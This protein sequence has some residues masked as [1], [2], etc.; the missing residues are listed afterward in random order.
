MRASMLEVLHQ[1]YMRT[2]RAKGLPGFRVLLKHG[3]RNGLIPIVTLVGLSIP[4]LIG[5]AAITEAVFSWPGL[6]N[7]AVTSVITRDYPV[8]LATVMIGGVMVILGNL[9]ADVLYAVV[10]PRIK[11]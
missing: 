8:V 10:D 9:L 5:G 1:D 11:Y 6:G 2:A 3:L 4:A 7:L